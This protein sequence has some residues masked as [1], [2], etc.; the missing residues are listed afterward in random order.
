[1]MAL[2]TRQFGVLLTAILLG[3]G[4]KLPT[5][6]TMASDSGVHSND[7]E[8]ESSTKN[9]SGNNAPDTGANPPPSNDAG[10]PNPFDACA[11]C[12]ENK[13]FCDS[14]CARCLTIDAPNSNKGS[15]ACQMSGILNATGDG[16]AVEV[17]G[18]ISGYCQNVCGPHCLY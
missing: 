7:V 8:S 5:G 15:P 10:L 9:D 3:C 16:N 13:C 6:S 4:G 11:A 18:C 14:N 17:C 12:T 2:R 1:M